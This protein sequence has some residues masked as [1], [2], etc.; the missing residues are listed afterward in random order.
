MFVFPL[1]QPYAASTIINIPGAGATVKG[2]IDGQISIH[3]EALELNF[4]LILGFGD[5]LSR[6]RSAAAFSNHGSPILPATSMLKLA[7]IIVLFRV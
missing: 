5:K 2:R 7:Y 6:P 4:F 3:F 1:I